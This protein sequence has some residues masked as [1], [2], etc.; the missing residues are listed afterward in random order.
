MSS[1]RDNILHVWDISTEEGLRTIRQE[2]RPIVACVP[3]EGGRKLLTGANSTKLRDWGSE[4]L[5]TLKGLT[6]WK[7]GLVLLGG[8]NMVFSAKWTRHAA[9]WNRRYGGEVQLFSGHYDVIHCCAG[10]ADGQKLITGGEDC[11]AF[12]YTLSP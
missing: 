3:I 1:S 10:F 7:A 2:R 11:K 12:V 5:S 8:S 9:I 6:S 4:M